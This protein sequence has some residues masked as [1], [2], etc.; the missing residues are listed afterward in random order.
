M[1]Q[2][3]FTCIVRSVSVHSFLSFSSSFSFSFSFSFPFFAPSPTLRTL[4]GRH[5]SSCSRSWITRLC[6]VETCRSSCSFSSRIFS[7]FCPSSPTV[8][9]VAAFLV[10]R[11]ALG[12]SDSPSLSMMIVS[13]LSCHCFCARLSSSPELSLECR[14]RLPSRET[15]ASFFNLQLMVLPSTTHGFL[16]RQHTT[17]A[18]R[19]PPT[20]TRHGS[21]RHWHCSH[22]PL[23][24]SNISDVIP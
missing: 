6:S 10:N 20:G 3:L 14:F 19:L 21:L 8:H 23:S 18:Q 2:G 15:S 24:S 7:T 11:S 4:S 9:S 22:E 16:N 1:F 17:Q 12:P 5:T 13:C